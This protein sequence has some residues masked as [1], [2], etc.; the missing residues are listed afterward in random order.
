MSVDAD[1]CDRIGR[2]FWHKLN[3]EVPSIDADLIETGVL[4]SMHLVDL[5][6]HL[7]QEFQTSVSLE[8]LEIDNFRTIESIASF[9]ANKKQ[10]RPLTIV[11]SPWAYG[12]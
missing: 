9:I 5:L 4:D 12:G 2:I 7:E 8:D 1:L 6:L 11:E 10:L 3:L